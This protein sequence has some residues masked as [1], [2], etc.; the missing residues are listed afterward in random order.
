MNLVAGSVVM[1]DKDPKLGL[2]PLYDAHNDG[3]RQLW[4][5][6]VRSNRLCE[7]QQFMLV[8]I[9]LRRGWIT[10]TCLECALIMTSEGEFG[11]VDLALVTEVVS[12]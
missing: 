11:W 2:Y 8:I 3:S 9:P 12:L 10:E 1:I 4:H 5:Y 7:A 6:K